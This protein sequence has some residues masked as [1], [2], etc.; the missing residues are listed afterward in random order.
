MWYCLNLACQLIVS[1]GYWLFCL[2]MLP[3]KGGREKCQL[4]S[5]SVPMNITKPFWLYLQTSEKQTETALGSW[6][7]WAWRN[8]YP[9][10]L[11]PHLFPTI[12]F[13][14]FFTLFSPIAVWNLG[15]VHWTLPG[16]HSWFL[17]PFYYVISMLILFFQTVITLPQE[18]LLD[19]TGL[20]SS[21]SS[22]KNSN[23]L[24]GK[25]S[26]KSCSKADF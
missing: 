13:L 17:Q 22:A 5:Q 4:Q 20:E 9:R 14:F 7:R 2:E 6:D 11:R 15:K 10:L 23:S 25:H 21:H 1:L 3:R 18:V 26:P 12:F 16:S 19:S 24:T 8:Q